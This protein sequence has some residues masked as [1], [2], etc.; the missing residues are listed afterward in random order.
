MSRPSVAKAAFTID[1]GRGFDVRGERVGKGPLVSLWVSEH[2]CRSCGIILNVA[3]AAELIEALN[4]LL[5][6][7][8]VDF[9]DGKEDEQAA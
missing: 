8:E 6:E 3:Q 2:G 9:P 5:D 1:S 4:D 7:I